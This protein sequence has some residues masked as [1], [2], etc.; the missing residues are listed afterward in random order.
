VSDQLI[1]GETKKK[2][3]KKPKT[4]AAANNPRYET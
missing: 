4:K 2:K 3:I 1:F